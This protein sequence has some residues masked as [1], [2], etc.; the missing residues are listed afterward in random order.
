MGNINPCRSGTA[1]AS[2]LRRTI[3]PKPGMVEQLPKLTPIYLGRFDLEGITAPSWMGPGTRAARRCFV[4]QNSQIKDKPPKRLD[5]FLEMEYSPRIVLRSE[6]FRLW[7]KHSAIQNSRAYATNAPDRL[8]R[9]CERRL[10]VV[11][12]SKKAIP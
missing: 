8:R 7:A 4:L 10:E 2:A 6:Y 5:P 1:S 11:N 9:R 12:D 3:H